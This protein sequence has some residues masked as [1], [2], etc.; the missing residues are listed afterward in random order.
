[1][2]HFRVGHVCLEDCV[3]AYVFPFSTDHLILMEANLVFHP[4]S[5]LWPDNFDLFLRENSVDCPNCDE[6]LRAQIMELLAASEL[7]ADF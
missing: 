7:Q 4:S 3:A 5:T 1:M 2:S 6:F